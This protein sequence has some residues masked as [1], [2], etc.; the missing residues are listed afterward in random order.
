[1]FPNVYFGYYYMKIYLSGTVATNYC[2][3]QYY[4]KNNLP[5]NTI[6]KISFKFLTDKIEIFF[7]DQ[8]LSTCSEIENNKNIFNCELADGEGAYDNIDRL[9]H[10]CYTPSGNGFEYEARSLNS[11][12]VYAGCDYNY[13][14]SYP[15]DGGRVR[16]INIYALN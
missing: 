15:I 12:P 16:N 14:Y 5:T 8:L 7:N 6:Y 13:N 4:Y 3:Y 1:M 9:Y 2:Y 10:R 11:M